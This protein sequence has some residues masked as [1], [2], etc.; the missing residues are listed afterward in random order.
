MMDKYQCCI[1]GKTIDLNEEPN[2][3]LVAI[4]HWLSTA[5]NQKEQ[6]LFC[7]E[8]CLAKVLF[9]PKSLYLQYL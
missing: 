8:E 5:E 7:H 3:S 1:C 9:D 4:K 6:Q 2:L